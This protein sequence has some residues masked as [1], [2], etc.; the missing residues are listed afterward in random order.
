MFSDEGSLPNDGRLFCLYVVDM[1]E[2]GLEERKKLQLD[3]LAN[4]ASFCE[5][6]GITYFLSSGTL[7]GAVRHQGYIP[8][9]DD[10]DIMMP[11][12]DYE[13]FAKEYHSDIYEFMDM[14]K[15]VAFPYV[16]AKVV[17]TRTRLQEAGRK[18]ERMGVHVDVFPLDGLPSGL[19]SCKWHLFLL[20]R[21]IYARS[22]K[23]IVIKDCRNRFKQ[24]C[25]AVYKIFLR[26]FSQKWLTEK[27]LR[28][29]M[30]YNWQTAEYVSSLGSSTERVRGKK[31]WFEKGIRTAFEE[32]YFQIPIGYDS[33]LRLIY[34]DYMKLPPEEKRVIGHGFE[35]Y[36]VD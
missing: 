22:I 34:G 23:N 13:R 14:N 30:K 24:I 25:Y 18:Y 10:I 32:Y 11:R 1:R 29:Q 12:P 2:I 31:E 27:I 26:L 36:M 7:I 3:I 8:W 33:W 19:F 21:L 6:H 35:A 4:V 28:L 20:G 15:D 5:R 16:L 9:D 17:D